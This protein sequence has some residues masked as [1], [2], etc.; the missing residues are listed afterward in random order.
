MIVAALVLAL[1]AGDTTPPVLSLPDPALDDTAG[2]RG[3]VTRFYRDSAGDAVQIYIDH[4][5][6]RVVNV[7]ADALDESLA[8]TVRDSTGRNANV[9]WG[10]TG[11]VPGFSG[12][13]WTLSYRLDLGS[14]NAT[15]GLWL[16]GSMRVERDFHYAVRD[17]LPFDSVA[18]EQP[19]LA[20]LI[21]DLG[22]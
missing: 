1:A 7:W 11:A 12:V 20:T 22:S 3:Y 9:T 13:S 15:L 18:F 19:E 2:Y 17:S 6:G 8:F 21:H 5:L 16:L 10:S 14:P 4:R